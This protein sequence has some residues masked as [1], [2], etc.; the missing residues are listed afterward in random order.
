[1]GTG[2]NNGTPKF[3]VPRGLIGPLEKAGIIRRSEALW[4]LNTP[5]DQSFLTGGWLED[6]ALD[7]A[8]QGLAGDRLV[9]DIASGVKVEEVSARETN[10][11]RPDNELD[12]LILRN[13]RLFAVECKTSV[14]KATGKAQNIPEILY[15]LAFQ[16]RIGGHSTRLALLHLSQVT[17]PT[18]ERARMANIKLWGTRDVP[19]L[20]ERLQRWVGGDGAVR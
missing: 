11:Q 20:T 2:Q 16:R 6:Y 7:C 1:M 18:E 13:G 19:R 17:G 14:G 5:A 15:K 9:Q 8:R 10:G 4:C 3:D 12:L